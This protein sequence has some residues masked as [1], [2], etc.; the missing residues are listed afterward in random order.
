MEEQKNDIPAGEAELRRELELVRGRQKLLKI[1]AVIVAVIFLAGAVFAFVF[2]R[3][4]SA[5][6]QAFKAMEQSF[7]SS[8]LVKTGRE[9]NI[10]ASTSG[11]FLSSGSVS[12]S[13]TIF[14]GASFPE[15]AGG[16]G[17]M[18][19][20][21]TEVYKALLKYADRPI[22]KDFIAEL[23]KDPSY[24]EALANTG[25]NN[26][27][28]VIANIHNIKGMDKIIAKFTFRPDFMK[29]MMEVVADPELKPLLSGMPQ[30]GRLPAA[31]AG[32]AIPQIPAAMPLPAG[33]QERNP[34]G[35]GSDTE[36]KFDPSAINGGAQSDSVA[37]KRKAPPP[38]GN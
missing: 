38:V 16:P 7:P 12:S 1:G 36:I 21:A 8:G 26:P 25:S 11:L 10:N 5:A 20:G 27:M 29:L 18:P 35:P 34:V 3:K 24:R 37:V 14:N 22:V 17:E 13:L 15:A 28:K 31:G 33:T 9:N 30:L 19:A 32:M 23:K 4:I 2:Y 6:S